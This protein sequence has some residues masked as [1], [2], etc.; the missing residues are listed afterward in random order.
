[1]YGLVIIGPTP[2]AGQTRQTPSPPELIPVLPGRLGGEMLN[3]SD[4]MGQ[5]I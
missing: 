2:N 3:I 1:M 4:E 5:V